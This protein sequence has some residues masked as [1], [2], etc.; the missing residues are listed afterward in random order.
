MH[1]RAEAIASGDTSTCELESAIM[2]TRLHILTALSVTL[3]ACGGGGQSDGAGGSD[4]ATSMSTASGANCQPSRGPSEECCIELG[5]DACG[6]GL[7]CAAFDGRTVTTCYVDRIRMDGEEC[8]ADTNCASLSCHPTLLRCRAMPTAPCD[9]ALGCSDAIDGTYACSRFDLRCRATDGSADSPCDENA[10][11][12]TQMCTNGSCMEEV[13]PPEVPC[14]M[15]CLGCATPPTQACS[16][17]VQQQ[18]EMCTQSECCGQVV[19]GPT[20]NADTNCSQ[21]VQCIIESGNTAM[22]Q[23]M[24]PAGAAVLAEEMLRTCGGCPPP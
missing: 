13:M 1:R 20:C 23:Q 15:G 3:F 24:Y 19:L 16:T 6:A 18:L 17:C 12:A 10:E 22:C 7:F 14:G 2:H 4:A 21:L 8:D 9:T 5:V 11:C